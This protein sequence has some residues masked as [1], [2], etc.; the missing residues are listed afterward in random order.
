MENS[1][2]Q[3]IVSGWQ[4]VIFIICIPSAYLIYR[5]A[6]NKN[7]RLWGRELKDYGDSRE[8]TQMSIKYHYWS[9]ALNSTGLFL[10]IIMVFMLAQKGPIYIDIGMVFVL[11]S[12]VSFVLFESIAREADKQVAA[13][14][15][16]EEENMHKEIIKNL[17]GKEIK[18]GSI[19]VPELDTMTI[20]NNQYKFNYK[21]GKPPGKEE[22][23]PATK[24][25]N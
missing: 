2:W 1:W 20:E 18:V 5:Y 13:K 3:S 8:A 24:G 23:P 16:I 6:T 10:G 11:L 7:G 4:I 14:K 12:V 17:Q 25:S 9:T 19:V 22:A 15:A 21:Q